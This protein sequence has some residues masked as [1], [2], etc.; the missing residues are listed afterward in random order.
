MR[1]VGWRVMA[2]GF[3]VACFGLSLAACDDDTGKTNDMAMP[4]DMA[5]QVTDDLSV[6]PQP[7]MAV[8]KGTARILLA[9]VQ[10]NIYNPANGG[11]TPVSSNA[12]VLQT[13][14]TTP[15]LSLPSD[16]VETGL[17]T[18]PGSI[19]GC[20]ADRFS[21]VNLADQ[22]V[23][24]PQADEDVG[25]VVMSGYT[26]GIATNGVMTGPVP[27]T[28]L[29]QRGPAQAPF[30]GCAFAVTNDGGVNQFQGVSP[31]SLF[32][33]NGVSD[34]IANGATISFT[35]P[36]GGDYTTAI[37]VEAANVPA[38]LTI[39]SIK[40]AGT[41]I[42]STNLDAIGTLASTDDLE[43]QW[44]CDGSAT[45]GAG[46]SG[47]PNPLDLVVVVMLTSGN[48]RPT[49]KAPGA[50]NPNWGQ[51]SCFEQTAKGATSPNGTATVKVPAAAIAAWKGAA[52]NPNGSYNISIVRVQAGIGFSN[53]HTVFAAAGQ[54]RF[55]LNNF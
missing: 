33:P 43:I 19:H 36:G 23:K 1:S 25:T 24:L 12:H 11:A 30:Y 37:N 54:G 45:A 18:S 7:D 47:T 29:C 44:S 42:G 35:A 10:G 5:M 14:V 8:A 22:G 53:G 52:S 4:G 31:S 55:G 51:I 48:Q 15:K 3:A 9:D 38:A 49:F 16:F 41:S 28:I 21:L 20:I 13:L 32:F 27:N 39:T 17:S 6:T 40:K 26:A 2:S 34:P 50:Q 46:C